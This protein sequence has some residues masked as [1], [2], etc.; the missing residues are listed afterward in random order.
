VQ[1]LVPGETVELV[2]DLFPVSHLFMQGHS[3]RVS[4][5]GADVDNFR[6]PE[7][8]PAPTWTVY[9]GGTNASYMDVP[10]V[11]SD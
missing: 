6:T 2:I 3:V 9:R 5:A 11:P 4:L 1:P 10:V 8:A 7:L